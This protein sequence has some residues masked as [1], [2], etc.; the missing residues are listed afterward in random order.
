MRGLCGRERPLFTS[1]LY[2]I[3]RLEVTVLGIS[4]CA[5]EPRQDIAEVLSRRQNHKSTIGFLR[6]A[7]CPTK[8][9]PAIPD[10]L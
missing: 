7:H 9:I 4:V 1:F 5:E 10:A 2:T 3:S 6:T 8:H